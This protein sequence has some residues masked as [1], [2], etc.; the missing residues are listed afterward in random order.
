ME[1]AA[2]TKMKVCAR[3]KTF[4]FFHIFQAF[5][6]IRP[7]Y[8][9]ENEKIV[10]PEGTSGRRLKVINPDSRAVVCAVL[11]QEINKQSALG[12]MLPL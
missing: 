11:R 8:G 1:Q 3:K 6:R 7:I 5:V 9:A 4:I 12:Q 2:E 10:R